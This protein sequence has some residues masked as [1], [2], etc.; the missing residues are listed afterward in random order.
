MEQ[1]KLVS[2]DFFPLC[3]PDIADTVELTGTWSTEGLIA[4]VSQLLADWQAQGTHKVCT[5]RASRLGMDGYTMVKLL[6]Q[7]VT[8][9]IQAI[10]CFCMLRQKEKLEY[11]L[12]WFCLEHFQG[13]SSQ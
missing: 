6:E 4:S 5:I 7:D 2:M 12:L 3:L 13:F 9:S 10:F 8:S 1:T 11:C